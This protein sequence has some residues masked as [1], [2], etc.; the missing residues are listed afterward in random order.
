MQQESQ[1]FLLIK[2]G[3]IAIDL[4]V[5]NTLLSCFLILFPSFRTEDLQENYQILY[6]VLNAVYLLCVYFKSPIL[7]MRK[8]VRNKLSETYSL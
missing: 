8:C 6:F 1:T 5:L 2:W 4:L 7:Y 3:V